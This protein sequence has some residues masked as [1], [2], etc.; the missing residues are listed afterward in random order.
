M[1]KK[2]K[3]R[4]AQC[5][6]ALQEAYQNKLNI[7]FDSIHAIEFELDSLLEEE[8]IYWK[9]RSREDWLK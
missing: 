3:N 2:M 9:Q 8:E 1:I 5:K 7:D 4:I 6:Q